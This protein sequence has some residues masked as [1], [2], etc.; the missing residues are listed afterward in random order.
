[1][2]LQHP[3]EHHTDAVERHLR[4]EHDEEVGGDVLRPQRGSVP[5]GTGSSAVSGRASSASASPSGM[6]TINAQVIRA[7]ATSSTSSRSRRAIGAASNGT[8]TP[9]SAPPATTSYMTFGST[10]AAA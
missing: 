4:R 9:A 7:D 6:S 2:R 3:G 5:S 8:T 10:L 1:M